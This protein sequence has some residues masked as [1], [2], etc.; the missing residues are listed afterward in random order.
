MKSGK[1]LYFMAFIATEVFS[2][3][4]DCWPFVANRPLGNVSSITGDRWA[5]SAQLRE[6]HHE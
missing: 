1:S 6:H 3:V 5:V 2:G 4:A